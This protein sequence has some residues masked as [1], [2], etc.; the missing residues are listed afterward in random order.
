MTTTDHAGAPGALDLAEQGRGEGGASRS[1][2]RRLFFQ[3]LAFTGAADTRPFVDALTAA[4]IGGVLYENVA[5]PRGVGLLTFAEDP[6]HFVDRVRPL[7]NSGPFA[8]LTPVTALSMLGRTYSIGYEH[9]LEDT[10]LDRPRARV[11][12]AA[13]PWAVWYPLRRSGAFE[14]LDPAA[15]R[16]ALMEHGS[17]GRRFGEAGHAVDIRLASHGLDAADND[18]MIGL[19]GPRLHALSALVQAMR[20]TVQTS[21]YVERMGPFFVGR[22]VYREAGR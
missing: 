22:A 13:Y 6:A 14:R 2:D 4:R 18:F 7:V 16:A 3:L 11:L 1:L 21:V 12:D 20:R 9:D 17:L 10:L 5:D 8:A 15:Q 19:V